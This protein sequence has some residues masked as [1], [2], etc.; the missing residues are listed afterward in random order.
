MVRSFT[1]TA[2]QV[3][4]GP[5]RLSA[6]YGDGPTTVNAAHDIPYR[7]LILQGEGATLISGDPN[8]DPIS[9]SL[10]G[11]SL[12]AAGVLVLGPFPDGP[13]KLSGIWASGTGPLHI[14]AVPY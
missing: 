11:T 9:A 8:V 1:L 10:Y 4:A 2:A 7:Q 13:L 5:M 6:V 14:L 3:A 12:L